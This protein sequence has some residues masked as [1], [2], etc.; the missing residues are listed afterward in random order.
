M[1]FKNLLIMEK[2]NTIKQIKAQIKEDLIEKGQTPGDKFNEY[3]NLIRNIETGG[4]DESSLFKISGISYETPERS[5]EEGYITENYPDNYYTKFI[6]NGFTKNN[7]SIMSPKQPFLDLV[8][9]PK[10]K[11]N[12]EDW[13]EK[14]GYGIYTGDPKYIQGINQIELYFKED[15]INNLIFF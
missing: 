7:T 10:V 3:P 14:R 1:G 12:G 2:L 11:I 5:G 8:F 4:V 9:L 6:S 13:I 15:P